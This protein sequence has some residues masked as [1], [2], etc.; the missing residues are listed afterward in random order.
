MGVLAAEPSCSSDSAGTCTD[1]TGLLQSKVQ[2][3]VQTDD[4]VGGDR[5]ATGLSEAQRDA[6]VAKHNELR[7]SLGASDMIKLT[8]DQTLADAAQAHS[9]SCPGSTHTTNA[10]R[11]NKVGE[12]MAQSGG[13]NFQLTSTTDL[14]GSVQ[15]WFNEKSDAGSYQNGGLYTGNSPCTGVCGHY[16][17]VAWQADNLIGCGVMECVNQFGQGWKGF[18]LTCQYGTT[19]PGSYGGNMN[20]GRSVVF[21][22]GT[23]CSAC[24]SGFETCSAGLCSAQADTAGPTPSSPAPAPAGLGCANTDNGAKDSSG[25]V[26]A[27]YVPVAKAVAEWCGVYDDADFKSKEMCCSCGGGNKASRRAP[28]GATNSVP[29]G[30]TKTEACSTYSYYNCP[31]STC[32]LS[33]PKGECA[34]KATVDNW[35]APTGATKVNWMPPG[36]ENRGPVTEAPTT[37]AT[38]TEA[39]TSGGDGGGAPCVFP[40]IVKWKSDGSDGGTGGTESYSTCTSQGDD[41]PWCATEYQVG[42]T[43][44]G[45]WGYCK[46]LQALKGEVTVTDLSGIS[47]IEDLL[48][49][50]KCPDNKRENWLTNIRE[51]LGQKSAN[52]AIT[53]TVKA[54]ASP[55]YANIETKTATTFCWSPPTGCATRSSTRTIDGSWGK[56]S[57]TR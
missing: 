49:H 14:T 34:A 3:H 5:K 28:I 39:P 38:K 2:V 47:Q 10:A 54:T 48:K 12:N 43:V 42:T 20:D 22:P 19:V 6:V 11:G 50:V 56:F 36:H 13:S 53:V 15:D 27:S 29:G 33:G 41:Q 1:S 9:G 24:P 21:T 16:T 40:F 35:K 57:S 46:F 32:E 4:L 55:G 18:H 44:M 8:W 52:V 37:G 51:D 45:K 30:A 23:A 31:M 25:D 7:A 26:C 17:Q